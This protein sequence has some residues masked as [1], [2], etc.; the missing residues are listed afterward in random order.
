MVHEVEHDG[1]KTYVLT[2]VD[3]GQLT[4][5]MQRVCDPDE[6]L[7]DYGIRSLSKAH[8]EHPFV[9]DGLSVGY[10]PAE[11][12]VEDQGR[13]LELARPDLVPDDV[14]ADRVAAQAGQGV[15]RRSSRS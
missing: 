8:L 6:F 12:V 14:S 4:R 7:S 2:I 1:K 13:Q 5:I 10:E 3:A 9:F 15:R 11:S